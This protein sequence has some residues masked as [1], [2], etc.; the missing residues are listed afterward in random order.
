MLGGT[1]SVANLGNG[2][3][4]SN[5]GQSS[6]AASN[7]VINGATLRYTGAQTSTDHLFTMGDSGATIDASGTGAL[8]FT[9]TNGLAYNGTAT[10]TLTL[11]GSNTGNNTMTPVL[12]NGT[13]TVSLTKAGTGKWVMKAA[14]TNTGVTTLSGGTL[15]VGDGTD[16][17][18]ALGLS[19]IHI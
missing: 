2:G 12:S 19:L 9:N 1:V 17:L 16:A 6:Y 14:N 5:L 8:V 10:P 3:V 18:A 4:A 7:W 13:G 11:S 15:N